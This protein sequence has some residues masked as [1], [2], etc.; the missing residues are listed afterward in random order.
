MW[1]TVGDEKEDLLRD[2]YDRSI[3]YMNE[4]KMKHSM[5]NYTFYSFS[6]SFA[7]TM[8]RAYIMCRCIRPSM[9]ILFH[10]IIIKF[11]CLVF[12]VI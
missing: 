7:L 3:L 12:G 8:P 4:N 2:E 10:G 11:D 1:G 5:F 9:I 6:K